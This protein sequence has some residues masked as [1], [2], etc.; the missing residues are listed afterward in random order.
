MPP[1]PHFFAKKKRER[2]RERERKMKMSMKKRIVLIVSIH[3]ENV[4]IL[5]KCTFFYYS[6]DEY[7]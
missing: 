7:H 5:F 6:F 4:L 2:E 1:P 3:I